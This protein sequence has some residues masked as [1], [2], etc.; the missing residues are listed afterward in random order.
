VTPDSPLAKEL[1]TAALK[2]GDD[3]RIGIALH[4]FADTWAHQ[5]F[6]GRVEAGNALDPG[7]PLPPA[8]H[9]Q[10]LR[11][12]DDPGGRWT[13]PRLLPELAKIDNASR[14]RA[15][16]KKIYR[17]LRVSLRQGFG[18]DELVADELLAAWARFP[19]DSKARI[20]SL[21][22]D[23]G[24]P[25]YDKRSYLSRAGIADDRSD[26]GASPGYDK[27]EWLRAQLARRAGLGPRPVD[28]GGRFRG[29]EL[30]R[31]N[32]AAREHRELAT[33]LLAQEGLL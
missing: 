32:E 27:I 6:S 25:L 8:G 15:A 10:A 9:L 17:Y 18:E 29:S 16:A 5:H 3:F 33:R 2:S 4:A 19:G 23:A 24:I 1:L 26:D 20:A 13:D 7:S 28:S 11:A 12:P 22:V 30:H 21:V 14:F 31:W